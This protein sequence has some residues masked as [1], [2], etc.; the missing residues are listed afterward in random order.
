MDGLVRSK[1][2][3]IVSPSAIVYQWAQEIETHAPALRCYMYDGVDKLTPQQKRR[4]EMNDEYIDPSEYMV[5]ADELAS[6]DIVLTTYDVLQ[7][8]VSF[9]RE[10]NGRARR[11]PRRYDR[12]TTPLVLVEFWRVCMDEAQMV[13]SVTSTLAGKAHLVCDKNMML[14][15]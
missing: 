12:K 2:T 7:R 13:E 1:A 9:A 4:M 5:T 14:T 15:R 8:E 10:D 3:L 11:E 6:Y